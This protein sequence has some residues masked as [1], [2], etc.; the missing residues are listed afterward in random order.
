MENKEFWFVVGSQFLYG[1]EVLD[2]VSERAG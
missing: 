1:P 2:T